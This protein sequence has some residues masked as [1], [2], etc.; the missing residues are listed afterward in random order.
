HQ[1]YQLIKLLRM[2]G[3]GRYDN[4]RPFLEVAE[5]LGVTLYELGAALYRRNGSPHDYW[6]VGTTEGGQSEWERMRDGGF[7]AIGWS[8]LGDLSGTAHDKASKDGVRERMDQ[9]YPG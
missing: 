1:S 5:E 4:A 3:Q 9:H 6:R 8:A 7:M 2:P